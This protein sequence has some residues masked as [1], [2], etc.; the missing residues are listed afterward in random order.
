MNKKS[1]KKK[2]KTKHNQ[3]SYQEERKPKLGRENNN[4]V[5]KEHLHFVKGEGL[6]PRHGGMHEREKLEPWVLGWA[7][8]QQI[9]TNRKIIELHLVW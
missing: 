2:K 4:K 8:S 6:N 3:N 7:A 5:T 1:L 9:Y